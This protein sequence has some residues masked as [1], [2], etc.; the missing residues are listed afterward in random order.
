MINVLIP[1][2]GQ[3]KRFAEAGYTDPKPLIVVDGKELIRHS[4]ETLG[5]PDAFLYS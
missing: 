1:L 5:L 4:V 2:A 3:G